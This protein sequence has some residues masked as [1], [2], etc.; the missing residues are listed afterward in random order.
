[1]S[2]PQQIGH[3]LAQEFALPN[4]ATLTV[5]IVR[6]GMALVLGGLMGW[7]RE[8]AGHAA[9]VR[10]HMLVSA[11]SAL[12]VLAPI[13]SGLS[14]EPITRVMQGIVS[15]VGFLGA[16]A[17]IKMQ[18]HERIKGLTTAAGIYLTSA[19]GMTA[20]MGFEV[21]AII[22]TVLALGVFALIPKLIGQNDSHQA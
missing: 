12:F 20:G 8:H 14:M 17:I 15:G 9:G 5:V 16:G 21:T 10:T 19:I 22:A 13:L 2:I 18:E 3:A 11:G 4:A 1:M 7:E 6:L